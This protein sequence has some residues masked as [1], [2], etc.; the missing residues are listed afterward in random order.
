MNK[1]SKTMLFSVMGNMFVAIVK[2]ISG[3]LGNSYALVADAIESISDVFSSIIVLIGLKYSE[4]PADDNHPYGHGRAE[5]LITFTVVALLI[6]SALLIAYE[7]IE[8]MLEP[9]VLPHR[10]T[11]V[12]LAILIVWKEYC[13]RKVLRT[14]KEYNSTSIKADALHHRSDA[15]TSIAAFIG[16][17]L[18]LIGGHLFC[19]ADCIAALF[20]SLLIIY[21]SYKIFRPALAEIMDEHVHDDLIENIR[22]VSFSV[23]GIQG[24]EKCHVRKVGNKY[25]VDLH[26]F[27]DGHISVIEGHSLSGKLKWYIMNELPNISNVLIHIEPFE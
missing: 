13:Y 25:F 19:R 27:V 5:P 12:I 17:S 14:S 6:G 11:L 4:R 7:S 21:N 16:I 9:V 20:A 18:S 10:W 1:Q 2:G 23:D 8:K 3:I 15:I 24:T 22:S 26:V